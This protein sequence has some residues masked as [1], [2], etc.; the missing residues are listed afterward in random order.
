MK[1]PVVSV[2][3]PTFNRADLLGETL[4]SILAQTLRDLELIVVSDGSTD[5]TRAVV[6]GLGDPRV[7]F[8]EQ[9]NSGGPAGPRNRGVRAARGKYVAFCD[10]DD[11]W[12]PEKL[13]RQVALMERESDIAL[14]YTEGENFG[15]S[16]VFTRTSLRGRPV[17]D[18]FR[19]LLYRNFITNSSVVVRRAVLAEVGAFNEDRAL[20]GTEDYEMW[21]RIARRHRI[22]GV[23]QPLFRYRIH[24][25][26]LAGNRSKAT[27]RSIKVLK[28]LSASGVIDVSVTLPLL[29]T[30][31][32]WL[33]YSLAKR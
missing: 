21:L 15:D 17:D 30:R 7:Q 11:L 12:L 20:R 24:R 23:H 32:K 6:E 16:D 28:D 29:W 18:H 31:F 4:Q 13:E 22:A 33:V 5:G 10:D 1:E 8:I 26:N 2:V 25:S 3:V 27:E 9:A 19:A 14:S